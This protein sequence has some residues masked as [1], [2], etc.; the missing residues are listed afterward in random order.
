[1]V[2]V[3]SNKAERYRKVVA[4]QALIREKFPFL[5]PRISGLELTCRGRIQPTDQSPIYRIEVRYSPWSS[6][7]VEVIEPRIGFTS[8]THM[9][10]NGTLCL[11]DWRE[12]P[13]QRRWHLHETIIPWTAE[14]LVF[15]EIWVLTGKWLGK[16]AVHDESKPSPVVPMDRSPT[17]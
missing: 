9:Y 4:E 12:H 3:P 7:E 6:P 17:P 1:M 2:I 5:N 13:W 8:G 11:Y 10:H 15:Y 16:S 14:W